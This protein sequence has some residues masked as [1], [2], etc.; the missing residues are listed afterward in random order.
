M[1]RWGGWGMAGT[2]L[3]LLEQE[4]EKAWRFAK[5][6]CQADELGAEDFGS[7][8]GGKNGLNVCGLAEG[9]QHLAAPTPG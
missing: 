9:S 8:L 3:C 7:N 5:P 6:I 4:K 2:L 1:Y